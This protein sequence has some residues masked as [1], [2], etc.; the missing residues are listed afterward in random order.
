MTDIFSLRGK[1]AVVTGATRGIGLAIARGLLR[2]GASVTIC[3]RKQPNVDQAVSDL[4]DFAGAVQGIVAH[5]GKAEDLE[6]LVDAAQQRFGP[7]H[8]LVNNAGTNPYFGPIIDSTDPAWDKTIEV[9][10]QGPLRLSRLVARTMLSTGGGSIINIASVAGLTPLL[11]QGIYC[12]SKAG[13]IMLTKV[14]A[15]ELGGHGVRVNCICPGLVQTRLSEVLW[16]DPAVRQA[17][18][19][20][21]ALGRIG[22]PDEIVGAAVYLASDASSFT[23]G[24]VVPV[25]GGP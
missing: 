10:L 4:G 17:M 9:N 1:N 15:R 12:V 18:T 25:D 19:S 7:I 11:N 24:A 6:H 16:S 8:V 2:Y 14:M 20:I 3:G 21:T 23:T 22:Q 5:V 13:L